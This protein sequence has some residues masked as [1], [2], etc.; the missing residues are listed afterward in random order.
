MS[1]EDHLAAVEKAHREHRGR[2][3]DQLAALAPPAPAQ[4]SPAAI[5]RAR[6]RQAAGA[7]RIAA[8]PWREL[9]ALHG[10]G[11]RAPKN[12]GNFCAMAEK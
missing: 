9:G 5:E 3:R 8:F 1:A 2:L 6:A 7:G 10:F 4:L 11:R 12:V